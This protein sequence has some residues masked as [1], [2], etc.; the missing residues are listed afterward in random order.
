MVVAIISLLTLFSALSC[1]S[2]HGFLFQVSVNG[3]KAYSGAI[4]GSEQK[5]GDSIIR[6]IRD[7]SPVKGANNEAMN[8]GQG[9]FVAGQAATVQPGDE[10][11][12]E[13]RGADLSPW[14][15][16][17]GPIINYLANC[18]DSSC[19]EFDSRKARWFKIDQ[20]GKKPSSNEW[21][22]ADLMK[23]G[24][25]PTKIPANIAAGN[26]LIRHEI[27][28]LHIATV[29]GGA[30][31]YPSC[32][33]LKIEGSGN[34]VP[35][36]KDLVSFPGG[37]GDKDAGII[38]PN[39]FDTNLNYQFPGPAVAKLESS[40]AEPEGCNVFAPREPGTTR[41]PRHEKRRLS[42]AH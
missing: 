29:E 13:W 5:N 35:S 34:G 39:V 27:I 16:N 18:G 6:Q 12:F 24:K 42:S 37:Y 10:L 20:Q 32:A 15:H 9:A 38:V 41:R 1:V 17:T 26:Y 23:G 19:S 28:G 40:T 33:H 11:S 3:L 25:S 4:P 8:C 14:P 36:E 21:F 7:A 2:A 22:Q 30:E 31:F